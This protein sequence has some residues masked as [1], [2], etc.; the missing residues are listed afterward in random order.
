[1]ITNRRTFLAAILGTAATVGDVSVFTYLKRK[2]KVIQA[3]E[4][5]VRLKVGDKV[6]YLLYNPQYEGNYEHTSALTR[7]PEDIWIEGN[8]RRTSIENLRE[9]IARDLQFVIDVRKSVASEDYNTTRINFRYKKGYNLDGSYDRCL[10]EDTM[11]PALLEELKHELEGDNKYIDIKL[12]QALPG[13][14]DI[15]KSI[16]GYKAILEKISE[17][18][19][20]MKALEINLAIYR[21][22]SLNGTNPA[23]TV[24]GPEIK[25]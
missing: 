7:I 13:N 12:E 10:H 3:S 18:Q 9:L 8:V 17:A 19:N 20:R 11:T 4:N 25:P 2:R 16:A 5:L 1:M 24:A 14:H 22:T 15:N 21:Y 6:I 23:L